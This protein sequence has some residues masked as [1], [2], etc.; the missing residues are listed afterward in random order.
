MRPQGKAP[1]RSCGVLCSELLGFHVERGGRDGQRR[2]KEEEEEEKEREEEEKDG[3]RQDRA[4]AGAQ[5]E[6]SRA[7][8]KC[9]PTQRDGMTFNGLSL[10]FSGFSQE[11][12]I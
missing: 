2:G 10:L 12:R 11:T 6:S 1:T 7:R 3:G 9:E 4:K 5:K 8:G